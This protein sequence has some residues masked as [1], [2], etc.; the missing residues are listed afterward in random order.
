MRIHFLSAIRA[1]LAPRAL[2]SR[3]GGVAITVAVLMTV[4]IGFVALGTEGAALLMTSRQMQAAA[5]AAARAAAVART[6]GYPTVYADEAKALAG[7]AGFVNGVGSTTVVV[8]SPPTS[9]SYSGNTDAVQVVITQVQPL[10]LIKLF[11]AAAYTLT[12]RSVSLSG[13]PAACALALD[14]S[15]SAALTAD[16]ASSIVVMTNCG[17]AANSSSASAMQGDN[18]AS[19]TANWLN[20][21]GSGTQNGGATF[22]I[23]GA[24]RTGGTAIANPYAAR[25]PITTGTCLGSNAGVRS[26]AGTLTL[27]PNVYCGNG[28]N[29][30]ANGANIVLNPGTYII[31][32]ADFRASANS[33]ISGTGVTILLT[34]T[35]TGAN[36]GRVVIGGGA[37]INLRA[38]TTGTFSGML[39]FQD[40]R[41]PTGGATT[42]ST[43]DSTGS[44]TLNGAVYFPNTTLHFSTGTS[45][46]S[47]CTQVLARRV[48]FDVGAVN[49]KGNCNGFGTL[50]AGGT[51]GRLVE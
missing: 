21:V 16:G 39:F 32:D 10:L 4:L 43:I 38:P 19:V 31:R 34:T 29:A 41:K 7:A 37:V 28:I 20:V 25:V 14:A 17:V 27:S 22:N 36:V 18:N 13:E 42:E 48:L 51:P 50:P 45:T 26:T 2:S 49:I 1:C 6:V 33:S 30:S 44:I 40:I 46:A 47:I 35:G 5:D 15:V 8:S 9:G 24:I 12:A 3:R 11:H 23:S